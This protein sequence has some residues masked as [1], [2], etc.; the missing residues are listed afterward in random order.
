MKRELFLSAALLSLVACG[1]GGGGGENTEGGFLGPRAPEI[2]LT[3]DAES[4]L[5]NPSGAR[6]GNL[7][8]KAIATVQVYASQGNI[9]VENGDEELVVTINHKLSTVEGVLYCFQIG[10]K[11]CTEKVKDKDGNDI[12]VLKP[13]RNQILDLAAGFRTFAVTATTGEVGQ[14]AVNV[15][16]HGPNGAS[17]S[18]DI[19]IP[20]KYNS[21]GVGRSI[22]ISASDIMRPN[23]ATNAYVV[24]TDEAGNIISDPESNNVIVTAT[25]LDG[26]I[27]GFNGKKGTSVNAKTEAGVA[28]ISVLPSRNGYLTLTA[29]TDVDDNNIDNGIQDV[30]SVSKTIQV[31]DKAE[32]A[33]GNIVITTSVLPNGV[34][35]SSYN[36]PGGLTIETSGAP[37]ADISLVSGGLPPGMTFAGGVL[38]G[39]PTVAGD[40]TFEIQAVGIN[41]SRASKELKLKVRSTGFTFSLEQFATLNTVLDLNPGGE[42]QCSFPSQI[43]QLVSTEGY[44]M[45][46]PFTWEMDAGGVQ[47]ALGANKAVRVV[48]ANGVDL[49]DLYFT[50]TEE[51]T[52]VTLNG[53]VCPTAPADVFTGHAIILRATDAN[54][55]FF[56]SVLPLVITRDIKAVKPEKPEKPEEITVTEITLPNGKVDEDYGQSIPGSVANSVSSGE[57]PKGLTLSSGYISG[58]PKVKGTYVFTVK[59]GK[60][61]TKVIL[62]IDPA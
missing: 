27:L 25:N 50:V 6:Y 3:S 62:T 17:G 1:G 46:P 58:K 45:S 52:Q 30:L 9:P 47:T 8:S 37:A 35:G 4:I 36:G 5:P 7:S 19:I 41:G 14:I 29:Q 60:K 11:N 57:L 13:M 28:E 21:S 42:S 54:G 15:R 39:T 16:V 61:V 56:E 48:S 34:V 12:E 24:I 53:K 20:V 43:L 33:T 59:D 49:P 44:T 18:K 2:T 51:S 40:Y 10:N 23:S 31:S 55:V 26:T 22:E 32:V 38:S